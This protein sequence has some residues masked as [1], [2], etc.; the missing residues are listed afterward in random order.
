[1][2]Q[3]IAKHRA[4]DASLTMHHTPLLSAWHLTK[5]FSFDAKHVCILNKP[6]V[7]QFTLNMFRN[8]TSFT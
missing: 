5:F 3:K 2:F 8:A 6:G 4:N 7:W 1:M